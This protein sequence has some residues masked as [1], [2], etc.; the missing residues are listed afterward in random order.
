MWIEMWV[1]DRYVYSRHR[2]IKAE[3]GSCL[4]SPV[5]YIARKGVAETAHVA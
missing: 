5:E 1:L 4:A 2:R 3:R